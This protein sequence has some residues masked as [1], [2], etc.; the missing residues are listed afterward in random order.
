MDNEKVYQLLQAYGT[1]ECEIW[2]E[3]HPFDGDICW[4]KCHSFQMSS[5]STGY[6]LNWT[7]VDESVRGLSVDLNKHKNKR[8]S[9]FDKASYPK[10]CVDNF[11]GGWWYR[12]CVNIFLNGV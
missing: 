4:T 3:V 10:Y 7:D 9:T 12:E 8:F 5:E 1:T 11:K 2:V 6:R